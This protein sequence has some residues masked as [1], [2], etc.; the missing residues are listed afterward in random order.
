MGQA[1]KHQ[2][3]LPPTIARLPHAPPLASSPRLL[4]GPLLHPLP[5][6]A[7]PAAGLCAG[8]HCSRRR[9]PLPDEAIFDVSPRPANRVLSLSQGKAF[10]HRH[11][12]QLLRVEFEISVLAR[13]RRPTLLQCRQQVSTCRQRDQNVPGS[14]W[15]RGRGAGSA[16]SSLR[17]GS[18]LYPSSIREHVAV[19][20]LT[21]RFG[22]EGEMVQATQ[23]WGML[24]R[25]DWSVP[26]KR[27]G[28]NSGAGSVAAGS[29]RRSQQRR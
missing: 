12:D 23:R 8:R 18:S 9:A 27:S 24:E 5:L 15:D 3:L 22:C 4:Q 21:P 25:Q 7:T 26:T 20:T 17:R 1:K 16:L 11:I 28:D 6:P 29:G 2:P 14:P 13:S 10:D 19:I